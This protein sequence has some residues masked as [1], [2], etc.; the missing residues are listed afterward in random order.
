MPVGS[1]Q[2]VSGRFAGRAVLVTGGA[3][4][5]GEATATRFALEGAH[6][7]VLDVD[8]TAGEQAVGRIA[9]R[10]GDAV[11]VVG[12]TAVEIDA[13]RAV[14]LIEERWGRLDVVVN[15]AGVPPPDVPIEDI[16]ID[17]WNAQF[18]ELVGYFYVTKH[19]VRLMKRQDGATRSIVFVASMA[20]LKGVALRSP[21]TAMKHGVLGLSRSLAI[22]LAPAR[23]RVNCI[24]AGPVDTT[25]LSRGAAELQ[26]DR[27]ALFEKG[28][29]LGRIGVPDDFANIITHL[30]SDESTWI[31]GNV[32]RMAG[33]SPAG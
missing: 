5:I 2:P 3:S 26:P 11:L 17:Q 8:A 25:F 29:P 9:E 30:A 24:A 21:Y 23:I 28:V 20:S 15:N 31:T 16:T 22:E 7:V 27:R 13:Q 19:A 32:I 1:R 4:G 14:G 10:G 12:D 33:G 6:V 18:H